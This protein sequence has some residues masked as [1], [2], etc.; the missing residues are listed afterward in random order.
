[1]EL[2]V[3]RR[4]GLLA[5]VTLL[6]VALS[7]LY[8]WRFD[9]THDRLA[10]LVGLAIGPIAAIHAAAWFA[11]RKPLLVADDTGLMVRVGGE[12]AGVPWRSVERVEVRHPSGLSDGHVRVVPSHEVRASRTTG[13]RARLAA[14]ISEREDNAYVVPFGIITKASETDLVTALKRLAA[15][16]AEV[17]VRAEIDVPQEGEAEPKPAVALTKR[18][19]A[20]PTAAPPPAEEH[21]A[22]LEPPAPAGEAH[23]PPRPRRRLQ[24][25]ARATPLA[26]PLTSVVS[27]LVS[28]PAARREEVIAGRTPPD[29]DGALA[30]SLDSRSQADSTTLPEIR[31]LRRSSPESRPEADSAHG[32][33]ALIIDA[34]TDLSARAMQ[35]VRRPAPAVDPRPVPAATQVADEQSADLMIGGEIAEARQRLRLSIDELADRTRIRPYVIE[36]IEADNFGPCG[37]DFYARGHLRMLA[38][39][40]GL[41]GDPLVAAYDKHFATSPIRAR[42]VF[43]VELAAGTTGMVRGGDSQAN[44]A[45]LIAAILA[46]ALLW[47]LANLLTSERDAAADSGPSSAGSVDRDPSSIVN[48]P[49][50]PPREARVEVAARGSDARVVVRDRYDQIVFQGVVREGTTERVEAE[51]PLKVSAADGG[52]TV[53]TY[54]G[55]PRGLMGDPGERAH[56]V[57][58]A[59]VNGPPPASAPGQVEPEGG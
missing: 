5:V 1:M 51:T 49:L 35:R 2:V 27:A 11:A 17:D 6:A 59:P 26:T 31:E 18:L 29:T 44:W 28:R 19:E 41:D 48:R 32:N 45:A 30:L 46:L 39:V 57:I 20:R 22:V 34:T 37:G 15:G 43:E 16:R 12:W 55:K 25:V 54:G 58:H 21:E 8:L 9:Q 36:S 47:G 42:D 56:Q 24:A 14:V 23:N 40:L 33:V 13:W 10:L 4:T 53:L 50:P 52:A 7:A 38:R 3:R